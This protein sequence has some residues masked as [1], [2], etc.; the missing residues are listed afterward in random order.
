MADSPDWIST[1]YIVGGALSAMFAGLVSGRKVGKREPE[2]DAKVLAASIVP[3]TEMRDLTTT[4]ANL[5]G[6][7]KEV[8]SSL[9]HINNHLLQEELVR[10][11]AARIREG[12][13]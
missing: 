13:A 6:T 5:H 3:Q 12:K 10:A 8:A 9:E 11:A 7:L 4:I 2:A 1:A